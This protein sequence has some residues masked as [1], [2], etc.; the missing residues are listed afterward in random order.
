MKWSPKNIKIGHL[1]RFDRVHH[2]GIVIAIRE[3]RAFHPEENIRDMKV[4][5][6]DGE[7]FWCLDFTLTSITRNLHY[8]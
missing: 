8:L 5:W 4:L 3:S 2:L 7:A 6:N 1:V